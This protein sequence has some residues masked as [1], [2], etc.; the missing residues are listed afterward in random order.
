[1]RRVKLLVAATVMAFSSLIAFA[2][3]ANA[4]VCIEETDNCC[5]DPVILGK[6][7]NLWDC[8]T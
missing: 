6:E 5:E 4:I 8:M 2:G 3:P 7:Y 1:M